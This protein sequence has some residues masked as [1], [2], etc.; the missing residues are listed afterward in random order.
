M[1]NSGSTGSSI[2]FGSLLLLAF[3]I[4][5]LTGVISWSWVWVLSPVG[6]SAIILL[7]AFVFACIADK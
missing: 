3:I 5:K 6:I 1:S 4:L 2:G 7:V